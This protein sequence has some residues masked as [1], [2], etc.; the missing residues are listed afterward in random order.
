MT[1]VRP[2][3]VLYFVM[4]A[5]SGG[6]QTPRPA[7]TSPAKP[8]TQEPAPPLPPDAPAPPGTPA[9]PQ[10]AIKPERPPGQAINIRLDVTI[11]D[12]GGPTP[13]RKTVSMTVGDRQSGQVRATVVV[14]GIGAVPLAVDALPML[15]R[16]GKIRTRMTLE[17][18]PRPGADS[19]EPRPVEM[20]LSFGIVL[21]DGKK[22]VAAQAADPVTDRRV[23]VEVTATILK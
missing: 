3:I 6:A 11:I 16:D 12:E 18:Q 21:E 22:I 1:R 15:E 13:S 19:K 2:L 9:A 20:R 7:P 8:S 17:Y 10:T 23:S 5:A 4:L 14:P